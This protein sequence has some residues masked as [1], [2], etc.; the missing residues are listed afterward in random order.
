M[1]VA[2]SRQP[3]IASFSSPTHTRQMSARPIQNVPGLIRL[4]GGTGTKSSPAPPRTSRPR[5]RRQQRPESQD[6]GKGVSAVVDVSLT[7]DVS[8]ANKASLPTSVER[9]SPTPPRRQPQNGNGKHQQQQQNKKQQHQ[10]QKSS[11]G[12]NAVHA[13]T[14]QTQ[15]SPPRQQR[16]R[17]QAQQREAKLHDLMGDMSL[18]SAEDDADSDDVLTGPAPTVSYA[19]A[20]QVSPRPARSTPRS[21]RNNNNKNASVAAAASAPSLTAPSAATEPTTTT[22]SANAIPISTSRPGPPGRG[23]TQGHARAATTHNVDPFL[24]RSVPSSIDHGHGLPDWDMPPS[25]GINSSTIQPGSGSITPSTASI[26]HAS[27]PDLQHH[28]TSASPLRPAPRTSKST[29]SE[30]RFLVPWT[31]TLEDAEERHAA[32]GASNILS[33][34]AKVARSNAVGI[35]APQTPTRPGRRHARTASVPSM[36]LINSHSLMHGS[37]TPPHHVYTSAPQSGPGTPASSST[38][39]VNK[40]AGGR[41]QSAPAPA[42]IPMPSFQL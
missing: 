20:E 14:T 40:Y 16:Q 31:E 32:E 41:F 35:G 27:M 42:F 10:H 39:R 4:Q 19:A 6:G 36:S 15:R 33:N 38:D 23:R 5:Q 29:Q 13:P 17:S 18:S 22:S 30:E 25:F 12:V 21:R 1:S 24:S 26:L 9:T 2:V 8:P 37:S 7:R 34:A 11:V 3:T 28:L